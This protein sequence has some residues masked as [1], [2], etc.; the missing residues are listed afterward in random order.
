MN[1]LNVKNYLETHMEFTTLGCLKNKHSVVYKMEHA[2]GFILW[3]EVVGTGEMNFRIG[4]EKRTLPAREV[5]EK[6]L[7]HEPNQVEIVRLVYQIVEKMLDNQRD[8]MTVEFR[9][10]F[11]RHGRQKQ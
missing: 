6:A 4:N 10:K 8:P 1:D 2:E 9:N 7:G 5:L 11:E 3:F